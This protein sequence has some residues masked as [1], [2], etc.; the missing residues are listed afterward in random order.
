MT[1]VGTNRRLLT[2]T[3]VDPAD[4][5]RHDS[6]S[7]QTGTTP[8]L[9]SVLSICGDYVDGRCTNDSCHRYH[10]PQGLTYQWQWN[11]DGRERS[12][13]DVW[14][15][16][17]G[18]ANVE[19]ERSFC[20]E[21][22][23]EC[24]VDEVR[25]GHDIRLRRTF[26]LDLDKMTFRL[27][28][29]TGGASGATASA[30]GNSGRI[31]RLEVAAA[32]SYQSVAAN[33]PSRHQTV[34]QW[35]WFDDAAVWRTYESS[36][37][38]G[39]KNLADGGASRAPSR[40]A[41]TLTSGYVLSDDI[42]RSYIRNPLGRVSFTCTPLSHAYTIDFKEMM[43]INTTTGKR[44]PVRRRPALFQRFSL[45]ATPGRTVEIRYPDSWDAHVGN[46]EFSYHLM[47]VT[48]SGPTA[49]EYRDIAELFNKTM[50]NTAVIKSIR[51]IQNHSLWQKFHLFKT[52]A[53][54]RRG[55]Q[56]DVRRLFHGTKKRFVDVICADGFD[57]RVSGATTG[58][59][60]G[61]GSYFARDAWYSKDYTDCSQL[62]VAQVCEELQI[63]SNADYYTL[64]VVVYL[65]SKCSLNSNNSRR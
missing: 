24:Q 45:M 29:A 61:R 37:V 38:L 40:L 14:Y 4:K 50:G 58:T 7:R 16:F 65:M 55:S 28:T 59:L 54:K 26:A 49:R 17:A 19:I 41:G 34:W 2:F 33:C 47:T 22:K 35:Y 21:S 42:E 10:S 60:Y 64:F 6:D 39:T 62:F 43:Q 3:C 48:K 15:D 9:P 31:R 51:R 1:A 44:R 5:K 12:S 25:I 36:A 63:R 13:C 11:V 46:D 27:T 57:W 23:G 30:G 56:L 20:D 53:E 32:R 8:Q 52:D 18:D